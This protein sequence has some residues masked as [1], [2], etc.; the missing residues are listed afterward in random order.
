MDEPD[1]PHRSGNVYHGTLLSSEQVVKVNFQLPPAPV[2]LD[3][4]RPRIPF[5]GGPLGLCLI[6]WE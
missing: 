4:L 2:G 6:A 1:N 5:P 3:G